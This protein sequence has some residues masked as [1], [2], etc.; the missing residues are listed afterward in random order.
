MRNL[1]G[2]PCGDLL[3]LRRSLSDYTNLNE[4]TQ[5]LTFESK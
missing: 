5:A 1:G 4:A 2:A 3:R